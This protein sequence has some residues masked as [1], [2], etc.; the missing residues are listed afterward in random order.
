MN[1]LNVTLQAAGYTC[2]SLIYTVVAQNSRGAVRACYYIFDLQ[3]RY[4]ST[5]CNQQ[6]YQP[7]NVSVHVSAALPVQLP[8]PHRDNPGY[9]RGGRFW[10][11]LFAGARGRSRERPPW[12]LYGRCSCK[13]VALRSLFLQGHCSF[14]VIVPLRPLFL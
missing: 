14:K 5:F 8:A 2:V 12:F 4:R 9:G 7:F 10:G 3:E 1:D 11:L 13:I 6:V